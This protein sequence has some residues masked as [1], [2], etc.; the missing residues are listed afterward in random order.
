MTA[1]IIPA[2]LEST[3][4]PRKLLL[5]HT[6]KPLIQYTWEAAVKA[7]TVSQ[8]YIATD[9]EEIAGVAEGFGESPESALHTTYKES[10]E[11]RSPPGA[12]WGHP[13]MP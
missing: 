8:V 13:V 2:R 7:N 5:D 6:G 10:T 4:L 3:R 1:C 9:S 11:S 12:S